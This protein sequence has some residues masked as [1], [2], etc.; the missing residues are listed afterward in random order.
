MERNRVLKKISTRMTIIF[1]CV[2]LGVIGVFALMAGRLFSD[3]L[4]EEM[5]AVADQQLSLAE[6]ILNQ[7][8][9]KIRVLQYTVSK[10]PAFQQQLSGELE[11]AKDKVQ[12]E[13]AIK[14]KIEFA[15]RD[16]GLNIRSVFG[17]SLD[18]KI[19][20]PLYG[21]PIYGWLVEDYSGFDEFI[22]S[23]LTMKI[24]R[25][26]SFPFEAEDECYKANNTI[27]CF[28]RV[29]DTDTYELLGYI[30]INLNRDNL[31]KC[32]NETFQDS[33]A[34]VYVLDEKE[35]IIYASGNN[36]ADFSK[37]LKKQ[38]IENGKRLLKE[39]HAYKEY[40]CRVNQYPQWKIVGVIDY[41]ATYQPIQ[42]IYLT[43]GGVFLFLMITVGII[44]YYLAYHITVPIRMLSQAMKNMREGEWPAPLET[45][46]KDEMADLMQGFNKMNQSI[47]KMTQKIAEQQETERKN[48]VALLQS[49]LDLLES[50]INPHFIHN[51]L[52][53]MRYMAKVANADELADLINSFNT[54]LRTSM[55]QEKMMITLS[56]EVENLYHYMDIQ[57]KRYDMEI[58]FRCEYSSEAGEVMLPKLIL[59]PLVENS[60][61]HGIA[62]SNGGNIRVKA[63][64]AENRIWI[65]VW[66]DGA[67]I[68][69]EVLEQ[70]KK[71]TVFCN[72]GYNRVGIANVNE[73][74]LLVY[75]PSSHL[76]VDSISKKGTS[77]SFSIPLEN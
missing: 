58:H 38:K 31:F 55:S 59:Q 1:L 43:L 62:P 53:T 70:I 52:N 17:V 2:T 19:L 3:K 68:P 23:T 11:Q 56:E 64:V 57:K 40:Y 49:Q 41:D 50:Q 22:Q 16:S 21:I 7:K 42:K 45:K 20:D 26:N 76:V 66:D 73:R 67:G 65:Q 36:T 4:S 28:G 74:L 18:K 47:Q 46:N 60:L 14:Q 29:Y 35:N 63:S 25:P 13:I 5:D 8:L 9:E 32:S 44:N 54:L 15:S 34:G 77:F 39:G 48:Q 27:S 61:F 51:T 33:F 69:Q 12:K 71:G 6:S 24:S 37:L 75:G 72:R 30:T 10:E